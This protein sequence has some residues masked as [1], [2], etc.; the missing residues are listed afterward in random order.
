MG[1]GPLLLCAQMMGGVHSIL[2]QYYGWSTPPDFSSFLME[3]QAS[4]G[5]GGQVAFLAEGDDLSIGIQFGRDLWKTL[6]EAPLSSH[7]LG[8]LAEETSHFLLCIDAFRHKSPI[9]L[10]EL[11]TLGEIDRF[12]VLLHWAAWSPPQMPP[13]GRE[14]QNLHHLCDHVFTGDR[15]EMGPNTSLYVDAES[16]AFSHLQSAF[17]DVWDNSSFN[18]RSIPKG[19]VFYLQALRHKVLGNPQHNSPLCA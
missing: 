3:P 13:L 10:L 4:L 16:L 7:T 5:V 19:A 8:V 6:E 18:P 9:T 1:S 17:K 2:S 15:F 11:E 12:L 14:W